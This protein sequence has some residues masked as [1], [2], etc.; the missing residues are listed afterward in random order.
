MLDAGC[1]IV[2]KDKRVNEGETMQSRSGQDAGKKE[3]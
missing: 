3:G 1:D 2:K